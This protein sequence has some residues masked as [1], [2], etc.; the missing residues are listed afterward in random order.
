[1]TDEKLFKV[2]I[3]DDE[4]EARSLLRFLLE[5]I[6]NLKVVAEVGNVEKALYHLVDDLP[7]L[8]FLDINMP[9]RTGMDFTE[10]L[11][12]RNIEVPIVFV[13]AHEE[14]AIRSIRNG[15]YDFLLKPVDRN[16]LKA[17]VEYHMRTNN[18]GIRGK[19]VD[20]LDSI[21]ED[22]KIKISSNHSYILVNPEDIAF[23]LAET[24]YILLQL[25][26]GKTEV[27]HT[28]LSQLS[29]LLTK[30]N[31]YR[32]GRSH[33]INLDHIYQVNKSKDSCILTHKDLFW[34]IKASHQSIKQLLNNNYDYA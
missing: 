28:T 24:G 5:G 31:F 9:G 10:L 32:L 34:E 33:L 15:V 14:Y 25:T 20:V 6:E 17:L 1:M 18:K 30:Y 7:N 27:A 21:R 16:E 23:C 8:I 29:G 2:L 12:K 13:S 11:R 19:L 26:N 4:P 22:I 3:V